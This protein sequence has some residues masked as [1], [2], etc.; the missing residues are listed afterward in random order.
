MN[1][2]SENINQITNKTVIVRAN[3]DVPIENGSV[4]DTTRIEDSVATIKLLLEHGNRVVLLAHYD[5]PDGVF[6]EDKSLKPVISV[7]ESLLGISVGFVGY[8]EDY[9]S[10]AML[11]DQQVTLVENLRF[12]NE[13]EANDESF[14]LHLKT[15]GEVY[16][17]EAFA[18]AHRE[19]ASVSALPKLMPSY[20]GLSL[21]SEIDL[22]TKVLENPDKPLVVVLGGAKLE[23]KEPL[24]TVFASK[25]DHI[26]V[27]G[28]IALDLRAKNQNMSPNIKIADLT[29]D[30]K[31]ITEASAREFAQ[32]ISGA[33]TVVWNGSMGVFEEEDHKLG[34][35]IIAEAINTTP[36]FTLVG[37]GDTETA[38]TELK[39]ESGID[40]ISSGGGAM[41]E[42]LVKGT[43]PALEVLK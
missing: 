11:A 5:R 24:V 23:T 6:S 32:I 18:N 37:G 15:F 13:E 29:E 36:A 3:Y 20:A 1:K 16:V 40:H 25:A 19:H 7:L 4:Q 42:F 34:T 8:Q 22:L 21:A 39:L 43:L 26:L 41:L 35:K 27:G 17:N 12:W 9:H 33:Q 14:A 28:K 38:L 30:G 2:L 10:L 31:D